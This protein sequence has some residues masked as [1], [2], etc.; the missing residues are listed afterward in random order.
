MVVVHRDHDIKLTGMGLGV[1]SP[2]EDGIRRQR[3]V[4]IHPLR[5]QLSQSGSND[6]QLLP[7]KQTTFAGMGVEPCHSDTRRT[8]QGAQQCRMCDLH[9]LQHVGLGHSSNRIAQGHMDAD[10]HRAQFIACQHHA[11]RHRIQSHALV[12]GSLGLQQFGV[13]R[14]VHAC[15]SERLFVQR[16]RNQCSHLTTQRG[17]CC[18]PH[19][20]SSGAPCLGTDLPHRHGVGQTRKRQHWHAARGR[21]Q[22]ICHPIDHR[23]GQ[24]RYARACNAARG[25]SQGGHVPDDEAAAQHIGRIPE[26]F[27]HDFRAYACRVALGNGDGLEIGFHKFWR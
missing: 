26:R 19:T 1:P 25:A 22:G 10:Q 5:A 21:I 15:S 2:H 18:P 27:G 14:V 20:I 11:H 3:S 8:P 12:G 13:T 4:H 17:A 6:F 24:R 23:H 9:G 16:R 7:A